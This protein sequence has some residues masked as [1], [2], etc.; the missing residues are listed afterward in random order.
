ME[1]I[2]FQ[3]PWR[4]CCLTLDRIKCSQ[5]L[6]CAASSDCEAF[7]YVHHLKQGD[8]YASIVKTIPLNVM[9][10]KCI[11]GIVIIYNQLK[12]TTLFSKTPY[13]SDEALLAL[14]IVRFEH[15]QLLLQRLQPL[16]T[17]PVKAGSVQPQNAGV[18]LQ[19]PE[20]LHIRFTPKCGGKL[21]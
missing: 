18:Q 9:K 1:T 5:I 16:Q 11:K 2:P 8:T 10:S 17:L 3:M 6:P 14:Y 12:L 7:F 4:A 15:G 20:A 19:Q 13:A 21:N